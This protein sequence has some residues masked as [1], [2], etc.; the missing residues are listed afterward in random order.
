MSILLKP[1]DCMSVPKLIYKLELFGI[2]GNVLSCIRSFLTGRI[3]RVK[4]GEVFSSYRS[5]LS[6][7]PQGSVLGPI[8][9]TLYINDIVDCFLPDTRVKLYADDLKSYSRIT[10][11]QSIDLFRSVL[12][13]LTVWASDWQL[14]ISVGKSCWMRVSNRKDAEHIGFVLG[15]GDLQLSEDLKD[16]GV[17]FTSKLN[18]SIHISSVI[19]K[20]KQRIFL[21]N[22]C[23][24]SKDILTLVRAFKTYVLPIL[25]YCSQVWSP[26]HITDITRLESVQRVFTKGLFKCVTMSYPERLVKAGL[27]TL[28]LRRLRADLVFCYKILHRLILINIDDLFVLDHLAVTRGH[29]WKLRAVKPRLD[30]RLHFYAYRTVRV[31]NTLAEA[32]VCSPSIITFKSCL[33]KEDLSAFLI[34]K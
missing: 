28:E 31:W 7:V 4:V 5:V 11:P 16:L 8:L 14:P 9:F 3:Q 19:K 1:F 18:F 22:K 26:S 20:A 23:F 25:D 17:T 15:G 13:P 30:S 10:G 24:L 32:T 12:N 6:G 29:C 21:L 27:C 33:N 34:M 2:A